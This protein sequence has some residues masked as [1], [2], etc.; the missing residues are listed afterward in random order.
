MRVT[1]AV[2]FTVVATL[3]LS[4]SP[5]LAAGTYSGLAYVYGADQFEDDWGNEG[6]L[7]TS[8]HTE[9]NATCLWQDI[10]WADGYLSASDIDG[11]FGA[12]TKA[13]TI[14][15]QTKKK[16]SDVDGVVGKE[17]FGRADDGLREWDE[18]NGTLTLYYNGAYYQPT[19]KRQANGTYGFYV[20]G[21]DEYRL[22]GYDYRSCS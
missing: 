19:I 13:A 8:T 18:D 10:L 20:A 12:K 5:A 16:L 15:W 7:S 21:T 6:V 9:S 22:A 11:D 17:T 2:L 3:V 14:A 4:T 1:L